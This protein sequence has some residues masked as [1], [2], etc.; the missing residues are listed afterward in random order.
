MQDCIPYLGNTYIDE[1]CS[2]GLLILFLFTVILLYSLLSTDLTKDIF[3][4]EKV[5]EAIQYLN[6]C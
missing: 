5:N 2:V 6:T 4:N 1:L 3:E